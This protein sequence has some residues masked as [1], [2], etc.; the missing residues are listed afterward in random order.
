MS[1]DGDNMPSNFLIFVSK[2]DN[3]I[4]LQIKEI[5]EKAMTVLSPYGPP[6]DHREDPGRNGG[7]VD[8]PTNE[9]FVSLLE[10]VR[11]IYQVMLLSFYKIL[12]LRVAI[13]NKICGS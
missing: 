10:L 7:Q 9:P 5:K 1:Y 8:Q 6:R 13:Y 3:I 2:I 12:F 11:E 4:L